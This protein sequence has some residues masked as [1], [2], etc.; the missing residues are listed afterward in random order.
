MK[1][2]RVVDLADPGRLRALSHPLRM[3]LL[4]HLRLEGPGTASSLAR[5]LS[6]SSGATSYHLRQLARHGFI[7]VDDSLG[8]GREKWW[9]A[10]HEI[11]HWSMADF[12]D[13]PATAVV[14]DTMRRQ[15]IRFQ[16]ELLNDFFANETEWGRDWVDAAALDDVWI[17]LD[18][19]GLR[20]LTTA[21]HTLIEEHDLGSH[22][23]P[24]TE[25]VAILLQAFPTEGLPS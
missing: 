2:A 23:G 19:A 13:D 10:A 1:E 4:G 18:P 8:V 9:K 11:T 22:A 3:S 16:A 20:A 17:H 24:G 6:E 15:I 5:V 12:L 25:R 7:E 14:A 21:I